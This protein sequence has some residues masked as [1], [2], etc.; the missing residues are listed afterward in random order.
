MF[1]KPEI[2]QE[3]SRCELMSRFE[4]MLKFVE[5]AYEQSQAAHVVEEGIFRRVLEIGR[6]ALGLF[7]QMFGNGDEGEFLVLSSGQKLRRLKEL[8]TREYLSVFGLFELVRAVY[9]TREKQTIQWV[10]FGDN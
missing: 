3:L 4:E 9:G 2:G 7:F 5:D 6:L 10:V 8:H 1:G